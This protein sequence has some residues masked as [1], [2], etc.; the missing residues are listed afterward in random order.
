[1]VLWQYIKTTPEGLWECGH[2]VPSWSLIFSASQGLSV[3]RLPKGRSESVAS[4]L[5]SG[6]VVRLILFMLSLALPSW[7]SYFL[8]YRRLRGCAEGCAIT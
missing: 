7:S 2:H 5:I 3:A 4:P 6:K 1:M 8:Y